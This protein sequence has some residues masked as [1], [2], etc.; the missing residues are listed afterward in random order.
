MCRFFLDLL[1]LFM[2]IHSTLP[3]YYVPIGANPPLMTRFKFE[4]FLALHYSS[5]TRPQK[6]NN[7]NATFLISAQSSTMDSLPEEIL[8]RILKL[9]LDT[10][11]RHL[12]RLRILSS[13]W[14]NLI[15]CII[16]KNP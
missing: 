2:Q 7:I 12:W 3:L 10:D 8:E 4:I 15:D 11:G 14:R 9:Q 6:D 13:R 16:W 1:P 5:W